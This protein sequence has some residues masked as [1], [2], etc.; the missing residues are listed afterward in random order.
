[1]DRERL[2]CTDDND[3]REFGKTMKPNDNNKPPA[4][5]FRSVFLSFDDQPILTDINFTLAQKRDAVRDWYFRLRKIRPAALGDGP[6]K[7]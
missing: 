5:E 3:W 6:P 1:V 7:T 4:I 2:R